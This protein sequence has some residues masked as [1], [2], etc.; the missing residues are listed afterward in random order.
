M[1]ST[2]NEKFT[3]CRILSLQKRILR[4]RLASTETS[5]SC[6]VSGSK[7]AL[8]DLHIICIPRVMLDGHF[9]SYLDSF[10]TEGI[11]FNG[12][13]KISTFFSFLIILKV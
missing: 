11:S 5:D 8:L 6:G 10:F 4:S 3:E 2:T 1:L 12:H 7:H 9:P 13:F